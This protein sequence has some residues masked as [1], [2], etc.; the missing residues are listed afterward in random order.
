MKK[1]KRSLGGDST[2]VS[3]IVV[4]ASTN[5][6]IT[7]RPAARNFFNN[8]NYFLG[9]SQYFY[10]SQWIFPAVS[11][12]DY[13]AS[14]GSERVTS[15][16]SAEAEAILENF[17]GI[18]SVIFDAMGPGMAGYTVQFPNLP[19]IPADK[20]TIVV[21]DLGVQMDA[22]NFRIVANDVDFGRSRG[23]ANVYGNI[24]VRANTIVGYAAQYA[25]AVVGAP[26]PWYT[27]YVYLYLHEIAH[28]TPAGK[29]LNDYYAGL[30]YAQYQSYNNYDETSQFFR[31]HELAIH[32]MAYAIGQVVGFPI[33]TW[34]PYSF[35]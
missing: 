22:M 9:G 2:E 15:D 18:G 14:Y 10:D 32:Q 12:P 24:S 25:N 5:D 27:G 33:P 16:Q 35:E 30:H 8:P 7:F 4:T 31:E 26:D 28:N 1:R 11:G 21:S 20:R 6:I 3:Q 23:G 34:P 13:E 17:Q 29:S 19:G